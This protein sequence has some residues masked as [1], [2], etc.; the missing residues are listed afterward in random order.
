MLGHFGRAG[1]ENQ[2]GLASAMQLD[3]RSLMMPAPFLESRIAGR[4]VGKMIFGR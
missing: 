1:D 3:D 4:L 2:R